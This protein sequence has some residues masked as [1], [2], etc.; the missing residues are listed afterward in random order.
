MFQ[1]T[2]PR[3]VRLRYRIKEVNRE[4]FQSTHPRGVRLPFILFGI[5]LAYVSIHAP[6]RGATRYRIKEVNREVFQSTHPRGVRH[7]PYF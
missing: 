2:H 7:Y 4:V 5:V 6:A 1:S 3:G